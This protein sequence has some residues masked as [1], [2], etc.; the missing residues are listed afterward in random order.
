MILGLTTAVGILVSVKYTAICLIPA[1]VAAL[2]IT[3]WTGLMDRRKAIQAI[4][5][6]TL[7]TGFLGLY[8]I[9]QKQDNISVHFSPEMGRGIAKANQMNFRSIFFFRSGDLALLYVLFF[10]VFQVS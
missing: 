5:I 8:W 2:L 1:S 10:L 3:R 7:S 6:F 9:G 4:L